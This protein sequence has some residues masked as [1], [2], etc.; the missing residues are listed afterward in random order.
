MEE[1]KWEPCVAASEIGVTATNGV[2]TLNGTVATYAEKWVAERAALRGWSRGI[3]EEITIKPTGKHAKTD[4]EIAAITVTSLKSHVWVPNDI[5]AT[6]SGLGH[7]EG[8]RGLGIPADCRQRLRLLSAGVKGLERHHPQA[9]GPAGC[10]QR[11][12]REGSDAER[13]LTQGPWW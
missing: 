2:V 7:V 11:R 8:P 4:A 9:D 13:E 5:Q 3:A 6:G 1:L 12:N 10:R